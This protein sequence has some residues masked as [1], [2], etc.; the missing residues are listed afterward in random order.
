M[1]LNVPAAKYLAIP[2]AGYWKSKEFT[3]GQFFRVP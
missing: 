3:R 2:A 1:T